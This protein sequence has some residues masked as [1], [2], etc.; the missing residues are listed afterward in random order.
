VCSPLK[1][2]V[3]RIFGWIINL[4]LK[5]SEISDV[6]P[7]ITRSWYGKSQNE[8]LVSLQ[9]LVTDHI[10]SHHN[11]LPM[12]REKFLHSRELES[13]SCYV[14]ISGFISGVSDHHNQS[15]PCYSPTYLILNHPSVRCKIHSGRHRFRISCPFHFSICLLT[16]T[17]DIGTP[18]Y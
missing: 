14:T 8:S 6:L 16:A 17:S 5:L 10:H 7:K 12:S 4:L 2:W 13:T 15:M 9:V 3:G 18:V 1:I 11:L